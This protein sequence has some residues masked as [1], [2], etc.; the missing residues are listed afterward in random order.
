MLLSAAGGAAGVVAAVWGVGWL[1]VRQPQLAVWGV[2]VDVPV[3]CGAVALAVATGLVFGLLPGVLA[4]RTAPA[5]TLH[6]GQSRGM[7]SSRAAWLRRSLVVARVALCTVLL[8]AAAVLL[9]TSIGLSGSELGFEPA[10]VLT[11]RASLQGSTYRSREAVAALYRTTLADLA[12]LPG[13]EAAAATNNLPVE[14]GLN[15]AMRQVPENVLVPGAIDWR[16]VA[17]D[18]LRVLRIPLVAGRPFDDADHRA[19][20]APVALVNEAFARRFGAGRPV[21]GT[22]LQMTAIEVDDEVREIVGVLGDAR[23]RGGHGDAAD[24]FRAGRAGAGRP[25]GRRPQL[26]FRCTGP[27]GREPAPRT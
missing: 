18:Y 13:V 27:Y 12:R 4:V 16:Y 26:L 24:G 5:D 3:L 1:V 15:L 6:G 25:A 9:R 17:G 19:A 2:S 22:R 10:N 21:I 7:T 11:A 8:A 23:T 14:R 20:S